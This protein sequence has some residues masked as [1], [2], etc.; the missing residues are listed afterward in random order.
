MLTCQCQR[1]V[2]LTSVK[3]SGSKRRTK[4]INRE[5]VLF[6]QRLVHGSLGHV[7]LTRSGRVWTY[8]HMT[9]LEPY[10]ESCTSSAD[11]EQTAEMHT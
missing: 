6:A 8:A 10:P 1:L 11:R 2:R 7:M 4:K 3:P 5:K 9:P